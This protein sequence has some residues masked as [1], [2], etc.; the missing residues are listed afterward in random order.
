MINYLKKVENIIKKSNKDSNEHRIIINKLNTF[1]KHN[2]VDIVSV[3]SKEYSDELAQSLSCLNISHFDEL[4]VVFTYARG[5]KDE[6]EIAIDTPY[7]FITEDISKKIT[8]FPDYFEQLSIHASEKVG[9]YHKQVNAITYPTQSIPGFLLFLLIQMPLIITCIMSVT[10]L[11]NPVFRKM[12]FGAEIETV[13]K[14]SYILAILT[15][16]VHI[17][18]FIALK[19]HKKWDYY[20]LP[21]DLK[22]E[23][24]IFCMLEGFPH[25]GRFNSLIDNVKKNGFYSLDIETADNLM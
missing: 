1:H 6:A 23:H 4:K 15:F 20:R 21:M 9:R 18:E 3:Y 12:F 16:I 14:T 5:V 10:D 8:S 11:F 13:W 7:D 22:I 2:L 24:F 25:H 19:I 17:I